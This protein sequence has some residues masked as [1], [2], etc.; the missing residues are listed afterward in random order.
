MNQYHRNIS[1]NSYTNTKKGA[2]IWLMSLFIGML[3][4]SHAF[5]EDSLQV[6]EKAKE[7]YLKDYSYYTGLVTSNSGASTADVSVALKK[8][9]QS[10]KTYSDLKNK[11][12]SSVEIADK[13]NKEN[14]SI[15]DTEGIDGIVNLD[16]PIL[17]SDS[18]PEEKQVAVL[19]SVVGPSTQLFNGK[20]LN[21]TWKPY[22]TD[23]KLS[24][25]SK[26]DNSTL[27]I[28]VPEGH[29]WARV[30][31][32]SKQ[33]IV[34]TDN[35]SDL[36]SAHLKFKFDPGNTTAFAI[37]LQG[38]NIDN[39]R[40]QSVI[41][42]IFKNVDENLSVLELHKDGALNTKLE[43]KATAPASMQL[44][45]QPNN[46]SYLVLPDGRFLQT[47]STKYPLP[48]KG[49][50]LR[51]YSQAK[52]HK[53]PARMALQAIELTKVPFEKQLNLSNLGKM[54][55]EIVL[56]DGK[57][58]ED[59]WMPF[60][61]QYKDH[62]INYARFDNSG[63]VVDVPKDNKWGQAGILSFQPAI[64]LDGL[65]KEGEIKATFSFDS[66]RTTGFSIVVGDINHFWKSPSGKNNANLTWTKEDGKNTSKLRLKIDNKLVVDEDLTG[67]RLLISLSHLKM[68]R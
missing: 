33:T 13:T 14:N 45:V 56:F 8:Y 23:G 42:A 53:S 18:L 12:A 46:F 30:G 5:A 9:K 29:G 57:H 15:L 31:I 59:I 34:N 2:K 7:T 50:K 11:N 52:K 43:M 25:Y 48:S 32:E 49:Y 35:I 16:T 17:H 66:N 38:E 36:S 60:N 1:I 64:W 19:D 47:T 62:F 58:F 68:K 54:E 20:D 51:A 21:D 39:S 63:F 10:Y 67:Y 41:K 55:G 4:A 6:L 61:E 40:S 26:S 28:D 37:E 3:I 27:L 44:V 24:N 22:E 65:G